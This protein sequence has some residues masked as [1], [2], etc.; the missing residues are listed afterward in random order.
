V[1]SYAEPHNCDVE[2][3]EMLSNTQVVIQMFSEEWTI[4]TVYLRMKN[5]YGPYENILI[6]VK[7]YTVNYGQLFALGLNYARELSLQAF[8]I[9]I[10]VYLIACY[11]YILLR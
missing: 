10:R 9:F 1:T 4:G 6:S 2:F 8:M 3:L 5:V 7:N 11:A